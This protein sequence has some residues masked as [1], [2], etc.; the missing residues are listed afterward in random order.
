MDCKS[1]SKSFDI[2]NAEILSLNLLVVTALL[3]T[4]LLVIVL[5]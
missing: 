2:N 4:G 1:I 5:K 3:I